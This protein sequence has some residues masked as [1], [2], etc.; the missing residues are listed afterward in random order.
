MRSWPQQYGFALLAVCTFGIMRHGLDVALRFSH[1]FVVL[2]LAILIVALLAG[3]GPA[4]FA[5]LLSAGIADYFF[6]PPLHSFKIG[7]ASDRV[8]LA[9][10]VA[11][12]AAV[13]WSVAQARI[14]TARVQEFER[15][16]EGVPEM[17]AV[18]D[19]DYRYLIANH[20]FLNYREMKRENVIG[21]RISEVLNPRLFET[22]IK[23]K[24]DECFR[25]KIVQYN[26]R[27]SYPA[28]GERE[29][30]ISYFPIEGPGGVD[31]A[32]C[33]LQDVT[34][35]KQR[36]EALRESEDRYRDLVEHSADLVC[37]HDLEGNLLSVNPAPAHMLG[38][39]VGE[40]LGIPMRELMAPEFRNQFDL[41]LERVRTNG[42]DQ[43]K[44]CVVT[45]SGER[46]I[47]EYKNTLRIEGVAT[48]IVRGMAHDVTDQRRAE[49]ALYSSEK[50]YRM[51]FEKSV[52][53]VA[54]IAVDGQ[55]IDCNDAWAR[56]FGHDHAAECRNGQVGDCY[57]NPS[58]RSVLLNQLKQ[59][60]AFY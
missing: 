13:S 3:F 37:T 34:E 56:M 20:A 10:L 24:L 19:R 7:T 38:Y 60:G 58:E 55:V 17:V 31:R 21:H 40:L 43:G 49:A 29:L 23:E 5:T 33:V 57:F 30:L 16:V 50:R 27:Y 59:S 35:K 12:G 41:Y 22:Q 45:R 25:G 36:E 9:L 32:A 51:L 2:Y 14:R 39:T 48:P 28:W 1:S 42:A 54:I 44:L 46:R 47:W 52:A 8:S 4:L 11:V 15:V 53:G 26:M 18:V 6:M